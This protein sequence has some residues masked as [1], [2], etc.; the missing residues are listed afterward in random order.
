MKIYIGY[1]LSQ[2][3]ELFYYV[4][5]TAYHTED[6][7][8]HKVD[9]HHCAISPVAH[10]SHTLLVPSTQVFGEAYQGGIGKASGIIAQFLD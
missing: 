4:I 7:V 3:T 1:T 5:Y 6:R 8:H 10:G 9:G 2:Y